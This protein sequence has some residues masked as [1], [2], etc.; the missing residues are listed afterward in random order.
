MTTTQ[1]ITYLR[2]GRTK[3]ATGIIIDA[4]AKT[5]MFKVKPNR[6]GWKTIWICPTE[7]QQVRPV[8]AE[9]PI[10]LPAVGQMVD[11]LRILLSRKNADVRHPSRGASVETP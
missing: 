6:E 7:M 11:G 3:R 8:P 5:A 1:Q 9:T 10:Q 4:D 2:T